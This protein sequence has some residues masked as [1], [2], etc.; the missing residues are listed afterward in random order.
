MINQ[1]ILPVR[2]V[3]VSD[4]STDNT[5]KLVENYSRKYKFIELLRVKGDK[6]RNYG[7][8]IKAFNKGYKLLNLATSMEYDFIGNIDADITFQ[9]D[10]FDRLMLK[11]NLNHKLGL[12]GG[13]I[14]EKNKNEFTLRK[15]NNTRSVPHAVQFFKKEVFEE[16]NGYIPLKY[17]G[18]DWYAEVNVRRRNWD[19]ESFPDLIAYHHRKTSSSEG[20]CLGIFRQGYTAYFIG[21]H[22][23]FEILK[24]IRRINAP[25]FFMGSIIR[26]SGFFW[27]YI[28]REVVSV[29]KDF[30]KYLRKE[31]IN[32]LKKYIIG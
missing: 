3:I 27:C 20:L 5:D 10:Y 8:K 9:E 25:P 29:S 1:T 7:S 28:N 13:G 19:A 17:G 16:I 22:P 32:R 15:Y 2:W 18:E 21:S 14:Y 30:K 23:F 11:F 6:D 4:G 24:N 26:I 12:G 31:Q